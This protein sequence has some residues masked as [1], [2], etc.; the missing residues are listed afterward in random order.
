MYYLN[1]HYTGYV[2]G[3][4]L[5]RGSRTGNRNNGIF[6]DIE[7]RCDKIPFNPNINKFTIKFLNS[8]I[9]SSKN[10]SYSLISSIPNTSRW[11]NKDG[12][13]CIFFDGYIFKFRN[14]KLFYFSTRK[15]LK[16]KVYTP[17]I[18][19]KDGAKFYKF[20]ISQKDLE[21][22]LGPPDKY[23]NQLNF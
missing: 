22:I 11:K 5:A 8:R 19:D 16:G 7:I 18:G 9:L 1:G 20:P 3:N 12:I 15:C 21:S 4:I 6:Y 14:K 10:F 13:E 17:V 2:K 23:D